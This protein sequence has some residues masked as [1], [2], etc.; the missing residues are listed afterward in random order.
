MESPTFHSPRWVCITCYGKASPLSLPYSQTPSIHTRWFKYDRDKCGLFTQ[1]SVPVIF[2][3]PCTF[4]LQ[5]VDVLQCVTRGLRHYLH[6]K[7]SEY[8]L[9]LSWINPRDII[10][11]YWHKC[12]NT[13]RH[14]NRILA[15]VTKSEAHTSQR[16]MAESNN[17]KR[18]IRRANLH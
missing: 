4:R 2:E 3:S 5:F 11:V 15:A 8:S 13:V 12:R 10:Y 7:A 6:A 18:V 14:I 1:K 9:R 16:V 17:T